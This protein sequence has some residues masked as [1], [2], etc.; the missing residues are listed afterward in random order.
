MGKYRCITNPF[1]N[2]LGTLTLKLKFMKIIKLVWQLLLMISGIM[3]GM[4][5][6]IEIF[7][8]NVVF[9]PE[10]LNYSILTSI[11][12]IIVGIITSTNALKKIYENEI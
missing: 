2:D 5:G 4:L 11:I 8:V 7:T 1:R 9:N 10:G 12:C 6:I 3:V